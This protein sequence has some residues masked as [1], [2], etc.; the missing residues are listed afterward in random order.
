MRLGDKL[1]LLV[2][3]M[4]KVLISLLLFIP[5]Y[6]YANS[7][8]VLLYHNVSESTPKST[9]ISPNLFDKHLKYL[10]ENEYN[11]ISLKDMIE[12]IKLMSLPNKCVSLTADDANESIYSNALPILLKY[13]MPLAVFV[14]TEAIDLKYP[15]MMSWE[16][17]KSMQDNNI[18]FYN[19]S[20]SHPYL[21]NMNE[22]EIKQQV[23][24]AQLRLEQELGVRDKFFAYPYGEQSVEIIELLEELQYVS[25]G[26]QS[27]AISYN[28]DMLNLPRFPMS[29]QF[30]DMKS[31]VTKINTLPMPIKYNRINSAVIEQSP[32]LILEFIDPVPLFRQKQFACYAG[33]ISAITEWKSNNIVRVQSNKK[34]LSRRF[35][36]NCTMPT[37]DAD[38][39]YWFSKQFI[40]SKEKNN[41]SNNRQ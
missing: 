23:N 31:F 17:M 1:D 41:K 9:S 30:A 20:V 29:F 37:I 2:Q 22:I 8:V 36:Y 10:Y 3:K 15:A 13:N 27:G 21:I 35:R 25:F 6:L 18:Y 4:N 26:Q 11:V 19:H 32:I 5:S 28:N 34:I 12:G 39:Y 24:Q 38:R 40:K 33:G 14:A 7:C 16:Q